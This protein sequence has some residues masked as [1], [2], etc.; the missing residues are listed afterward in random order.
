MYQTYELNHLIMFSSEAY[1][2]MIAQYN[3]SLWPIQIFIMLGNILFLLGIF[4]KKFIKLCFVYLSLIWIFLGIYFF[5]IHFA[6]I[7]W[8]AKYCAYVFISYG[9]ILALCIL[10]KQEFITHHWLGKIGIVIAALS[11]FVPINILISK[12]ALEHAELF[13]FGAEATCLG[14]FG[15]LLS[16]RGTLVK[17]LAVVPI[18]WLGIALAVLLA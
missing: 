10:R 16:I 3:K 11:I 4:F 9:L 18:L 13:G 7:N 15:F 1:W 5:Q 8:P 14:A 17:S 2:A 6:T 12:P